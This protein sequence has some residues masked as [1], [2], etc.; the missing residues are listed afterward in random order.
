VAASVEDATFLLNPNQLAPSTESR[1]SVFVV[2]E[3][4]AGQL[5]ESKGACI[6]LAVAMFVS[7]RRSWSSTCRIRLSLHNASM[8]LEKIKN[9]K[10]NGNSA[11]WQAEVNHMGRQEV[12]LTVEQQRA[13]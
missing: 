12:A 11:P 6:G 7:L 10:F 5:Q 9:V 4:F 8:L 3:Q 2:D 1:S 13:G